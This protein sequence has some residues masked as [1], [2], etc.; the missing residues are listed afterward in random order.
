VA[1]ACEIP[2]KDQEHLF[3]RAIVLHDN[4]E[5]SAIEQLIG[6]S[7][8]TGNLCKGT[9]RN[10]RHVIEPRLAQRRR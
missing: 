5:H 6:Y 1:S 4:D 7:L 10:E 3:L 2:S 8:V 9:P